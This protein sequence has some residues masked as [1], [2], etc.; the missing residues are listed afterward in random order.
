LAAGFRLGPDQ[1]TLDAA[2]WPLVEDPHDLRRVDFHLTLLIAQ[3]ITNV[4]N[5]G[6]LFRNAAAFG[7]RGVVLD[8]TCCDPLYRKAIRVSMG[9]VLSIPY[10]VSHNWPGDLER[11]KQEWGVTLIAA[12]SHA[13]AVPPWQMPKARRAGIVLGSEGHGLSEETL[14]HCDAICAIP[15]SNHVPSINVAVASAVLL[16]ELHRNPAED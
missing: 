11:L 8:P 5:M 14:R 15:M 1:L 9:H 13:R 10:A 7:V 12:E 16:Y 4:D 6:A 2:L 3:G